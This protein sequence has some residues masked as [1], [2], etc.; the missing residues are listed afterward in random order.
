MTQQQKITYTTIGSSDEFHQLFDQSVQEIKK[1][2]GKLYPNMIGGID[3]RNDRTVPVKSPI[4]TRLVL[5]HVQL[6]TKEEASKAVDLAHAAFPAWRNR[7]WRE[8]V[9]ILQRA[10]DAIQRRKYELTAWMCYEAG[11][12]RLESMGEVEESADLIR[13]YCKNMVENEGYTR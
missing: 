11:K 2:F 13:Y 1:D 10:A 4:D 6:A 7:G 5:G 12:N 9:E 8:R 3:S